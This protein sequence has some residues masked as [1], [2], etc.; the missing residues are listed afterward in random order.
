[1]YPEPALQ[2]GIK[3]ALGDA[4]RAYDRV[5]TSPT[6]PYVEIPESQILDNGNTCEPDMFEAFSTIHV[7]SR[8]VGQV[9]AKSLSATV[10][11]IL[12]EP[13]SLEGFEITSA[14][15]QSASHF[16][17]ADGLT[18]HSVLTFRYLLQPA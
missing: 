17:D 14:Q 13:F 8:V 4:V 16:M 11:G 6:F 15:F 3:T 9:E 5:P 1:M 7:W 10:I 18:A 2:K 12:R